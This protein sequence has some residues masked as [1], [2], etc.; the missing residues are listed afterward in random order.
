M[1]RVRSGV[2]LVIT[3]TIEG[4]FALVTPHFA[5]FRVSGESCKGTEVFPITFLWQIYR[6][7]QASEIRFSADN[8]RTAL[9]RR[10]SLA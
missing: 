4:V 9:V 10:K 5:R 6:I 1:V 7:Q 8:C 2:C 3:I